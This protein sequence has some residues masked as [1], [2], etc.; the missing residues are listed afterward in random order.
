M[1]IAT[2]SFF[3]R[4]FSDL[5]KPQLFIMLKTNHTLFVF[6][7]Y[8]LISLIACVDP[9]S[10]EFDFQ[11]DVLFVDAYVL[12]QTGASTVSIKNSFYDGRDYR[13]ENVL[14]A[15][16]RVENTA[17]GDQI[18]FL[19]DSTGIYLCPPDFATSVGESWKLYIQLEDGRQIESKP[20]TVNPSVPIENVTVEFSSEVKYDVSFDEFVPGHSVRLDWK[21]PPG[22]RNYYL[23]KYRTYEPQLVCKTCER[24]IFRNGKCE[25]VTSGFVPPYYDY[26]CDPACWRIR[27]GEELPI[28]DDRLSDGAQITG[29]EIAVLPYYRRQDVLIQ[30]QQLSLSETSF[31]YFEVINNLITESG[32]LNAPPPAALLGNLFNPNDPSEFILGQLTASAVTVENVYIDRSDITDLPLTPDPTIRTET[33]AT[34]PVLFP[35]EEGRFRTSVKPDGWP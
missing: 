12:T 17:T 34:C 1:F 29:R 9:V 7:I 25:D 14:N 20:E 16:V 4:I 22:E 19:E 35:C 27:Y 8:S 24:G 32:G 23:W 21:D 3:T 30:I 11:D 28:F 15:K 26:L 10:P 2:L 18:E 5:F 13:V 33:C 31:E 6:L